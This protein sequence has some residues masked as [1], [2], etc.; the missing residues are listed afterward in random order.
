MQKFVN[1]SKGREF[2]SNFYGDSSNLK[3]RIGAFTKN[4]KLEESDCIFN[5][6][7]DASG[8]SSRQGEL[9]FFQDHT[10]LPFQFKV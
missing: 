1:L 10:F 8:L 9:Q 2:L 5:W 7:Y 4:R 6:K 3:Q